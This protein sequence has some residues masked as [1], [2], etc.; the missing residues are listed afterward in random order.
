MTISADGALVWNLGG[1]AGDADGG[2]VW[3]CE[4]SSLHD[5]HT[6]TL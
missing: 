2:R 1:D 3:Y 6:G 5:N 4:F